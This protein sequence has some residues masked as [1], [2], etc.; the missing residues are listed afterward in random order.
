VVKVVF[1]LNTLALA[2]IVGSAFDS[3]V[4]SHSHFFKNDAVVSLERTNFQNP[5]IP[6]VEKIGDVFK[7]FVLNFP[8]VIV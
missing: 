4:L 2:Q 3:D 7:A 1:L 6:D 8:A 5:L